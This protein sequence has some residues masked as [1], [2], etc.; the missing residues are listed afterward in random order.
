M[1]VPRALEFPAVIAVTTVLTFTG[2]SAL[3]ACV[4]PPLAQMAERR[5][6]AEMETV[7][8][9]EEEPEAYES[10]E[11][12]G[13]FLGD[14]AVPASLA[15]TSPPSQ[16]TPALAVTG[17]DTDPGAAGQSASSDPAPGGPAAPETAQA[18]VAVASA[19]QSGVAAGPGPSTQ[20]PATAAPQAQQHAATP[21]PAKPAAVSGMDYL[22]DQTFGSGS[23]AKPP[24]PGHQ[25]AP[26]AG[27]KS[28]GAK[29]A[30]FCPPGQ[31]QKDTC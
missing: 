10:G 17:S 3:Q 24:A 19:V 18:A 8:S 2:V 29:K 9:L 14:P 31:A 28:Q 26:A 23:Y 6:A 25:A 27:S 22:W 20:L 15:R 16:E 4:N 11:L 13:V 30:D 5:V 1:H 12:R 21:A 7:A